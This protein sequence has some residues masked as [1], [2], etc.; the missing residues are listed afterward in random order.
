M[1]GRFEEVITTRQRLREIVPEPAQ[2][3]LDKVIDHIDDVCRRFIAAS[4]FAV[5][6]TRGDDGMIDL[7]PKGDPAGFVTV[8]DDKTLIIPDRLGNR[9]VDSFENLLTNP[10]VGMIFVIP[11][12]GYTLRV[13]GTA[14]IV[15]DARLQEKLA[16]NGKPPDLLLAVAVKQAFMHCAKSITRS[17]LWQSDAW[18]DTGN[19]PSLAEAMVSHGKLSRTVAEQQAV[20]DRDFDTRMY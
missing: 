15:R 2:P 1:S 10:E 11:G 8:L 13:S 17:G 9:R 7:S 14:C 20:I 19:V 12:Y 16:V 4:P 3:I 5:I 18:P 6:A